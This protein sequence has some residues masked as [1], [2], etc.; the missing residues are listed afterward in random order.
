MDGWKSSNPVDFFHIDEKGTSSTVIEGFS[1]QLFYQG[2]RFDGNV[3]SLA[4][5]G[6]DTMIILSVKDGDASKAY[7]G[8]RA[9]ILYECKLL[10]V[11]IG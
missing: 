6:V 11:R 9:F 7:T 1:Y 4:F 10:L 8:R 3:K 5:D 2:N